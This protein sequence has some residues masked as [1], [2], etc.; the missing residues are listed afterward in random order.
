M[1]IGSETYYVLEDREKWER[2][3]ILKRK[4]KRQ[5]YYVLEDWEKGE[6]GHILKRK[7]KRNGFG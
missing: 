3:Y 2:G 6:R 4:Q 7:Q 1:F 5:T